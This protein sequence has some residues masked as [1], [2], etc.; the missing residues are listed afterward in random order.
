MAGGGDRRRIRRQGSLS[1]YV[2][3]RQGAPAPGSVVRRRDTT[4][5][6]MHRPFRRH[7]LTRA[8]PWGSAVVVAVLGL[9]AG[10]TSAPRRETH[11]PPVAA[12]SPAPSAAHAFAR[13]A[14][15]QAAS[16]SQPDTQRV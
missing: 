2:R 8:F 1:E 10:V 9:Q 16:P 15:A 12:A 11:T 3:G 7:V 13:D 5:M 14:S 6:T 4:D